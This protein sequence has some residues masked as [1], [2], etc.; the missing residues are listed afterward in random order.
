MCIR[1]MEN[2]QRG[3]RVPCVDLGQLCTWGG[4]SALSVKIYDA[5]FY[6]VTGTHFGETTLELL[7]H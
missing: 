3:H 6:V 1:K 2:L 5:Q 4:T 7:E